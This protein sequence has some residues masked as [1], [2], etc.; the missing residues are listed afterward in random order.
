MVSEV[1]E[2]PTHSAKARSSAW[3]GSESSDGPGIA[4][5]RPRGVVGE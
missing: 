4:P 3:S 2:L 5:D 1:Q